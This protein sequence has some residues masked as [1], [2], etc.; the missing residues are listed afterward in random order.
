MDLRN[1]M[2][3]YIFKIPLTAEVEYITAEENYRAARDKVR[4]LRSELP[5]DDKSTYRMIF[6]NTVAQGK[7]LLTSTARDDRIIG[8][9]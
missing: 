8:D 9:D 7:I 4:S 3:Y 6:A 2:P 5:K 1:H